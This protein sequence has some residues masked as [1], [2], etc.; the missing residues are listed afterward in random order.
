MLKTWLKTDFRNVSAAPSVQNKARGTSPWSH[1][2]QASRTWPAT[3]IKG[4]LTERIRP[5]QPCIE[6]LRV[7][8][9]HVCIVCPGRLCFL[10]GG[11]WG[12]LSR[13]T[14]PLHTHGARC[15]CPAV[16]SPRQKEVPQ[17][18]PTAN[19]FSNESFRA[20]IISRLGNE[21]RCK[22]NRREI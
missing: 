17:Q 4:T 22:T 6:D 15:S 7:R 21:P 12:L 8:Q 11:R 20:G 19:C 5:R 10:L 9:V 18:A 2:A 1:A 13:P 3:Q 14:F 16:K